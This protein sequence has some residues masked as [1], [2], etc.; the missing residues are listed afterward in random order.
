MASN[1]PHYVASAQ[2]VPQANRVPWF[3]STAQTYAGVMLW[4]VFWD[5]VPA[6][7]AAGPAGILAHG[8]GAAVLG[9]IV[10]ALICHFASYVAPGMMGMKTGLP[11]AVVGTSTYGVTGGFLMPGFFMG[12]LQFGWLAVN[13]YFSAKLLAWLAGAPEDGTLH[14]TIGAVWCLV[15]AFVGLKG[16]QYVAKVAT[17]L[18]LIPL[19]ILLILAGKTMSGIGNFKPDL[20]MAGYDGPTLA[21]LSSLDVFLFAVANIVGFFATAGAAGADIASSNR[22][23]KDVQLGGLVGVAGATIFTGC[24]ALL[25]VAGTYGAGLM[26][27][28]AVIITPTKLMETIMGTQVANVFWLLLALAA[29]PPACFSS[30]IAANSFKNTLPKVNP[31]VSCGIGTAASITLVLSGQAGKAAEM[32]GIIGASF[33]PI[34]GAMTADYLLAGCKWPGPRAGFNPAGWISWAVGFVVGAIDMIAAKVP[35]L[36]GFALHVPCPPVAAIIVGFVL[37]AVLAKAGLESK[38]LEMPAAKQ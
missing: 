28:K 11:L 6:S 36:S 4:F 18:P 20:L 12:M 30:L 25:I 15:A 9:V 2:P 29:F 35:A 37:Y 8:L 17:Y 32:F 33:G 38:T 26:T 10:A 7:G 31:F 19:V 34:C 3:K 24:L 1:L 14:L 16:I 21:T 13:A 22:D 23:S 5:S 27:D